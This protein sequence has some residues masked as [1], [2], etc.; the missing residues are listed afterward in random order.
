MR[1]SMKIG[2]GT[3]VAVLAITALTA[4]SASAEEGFL[5]LLS[6]ETTWSSGKLILESTGG[7]SY[8]CKSSEGKGTF[9]TDKHFTIEMHFNECTSAGIAMNSLGDK[10]GV[11]LFTALALV[12]LK[13]TNAKGEVLSAFGIFIELPAGGVHLEVPAIGQ[14]LLLA[15][16]YI[17][18]VLTTGPA[19]TYVVDI[20]GKAGKQNAVECKEGLT[21]KKG[22]LLSENNE[23]KKPE[24]ASVNMES[25]SLAFS[26]NKELME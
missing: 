19:K 14:L 13:P 24:A 1:R 11:V 10:A 25:G 21:S 15:G 16:T 9:A 17:G 12:C 18:E 2:I 8:L 7:W 26:E 23:N 20:T 4:L 22:S 3:L 5:P 6:K